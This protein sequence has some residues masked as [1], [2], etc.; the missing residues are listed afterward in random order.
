M[1]SSKPIGDLTVRP[2]KRCCNERKLK[3]VGPVLG[4]WRE[5]CSWATFIPVIWIRKGGFW[6]S[7]EYTL[8]N[9]GKYH[10]HHKPLWEGSE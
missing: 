6:S 7:P 9:G 5:K 1:S 4:S 3:K 8:E 10:E 2:E